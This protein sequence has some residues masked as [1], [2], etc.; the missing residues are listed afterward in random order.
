MSDSGF[1]TCPRCNAPIPAG[2]TDRL[3]PACLMSRA[4]AAPVDETVPLAP[5]QSSAPRQSPELPREFGGYRLLGLLGT[6]G[7]GEVYEAEHLATGRRVALKML[8]QQLDSPEM[9]HLVA[10][11]RRK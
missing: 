1:S 3:C 4:I 9:R 6:G 10:A 5:G 2:A 11:L 7:M 8:G